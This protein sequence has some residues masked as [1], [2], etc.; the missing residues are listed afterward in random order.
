MLS[1]LMIVLQTHVIME[2]RASTEWTRTTALVWLDSTALTV[3]QVSSTQNEDSLTT[4]RLKKASSKLRYNN[5][6][7]HQKRHNFDFGIDCRFRKK[8]T[9]SLQKQFSISGL[10]FIT[11]KV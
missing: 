6:I 11:V 4:F 8:Y 1:V 10:E 3:K 7:L 2:E 5:F 9:E